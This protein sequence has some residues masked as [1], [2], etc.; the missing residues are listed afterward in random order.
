MGRS[1]LLAT[2][3]DHTVEETLPIKEKAGL[4]PSPVGSV[5]LS[6]TRGQGHIAGTYK[7]LGNGVGGKQTGIEC[8][9]KWAFGL[10]IS[11]ILP[12]W[13]W[14]QNDMAPRRGSFLGISR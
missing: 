12:P 11:Q 6:Q 9:V 1:S 14:L 4:T 10:S 2:S 13:T 5:P 8:K 7:A 3:I